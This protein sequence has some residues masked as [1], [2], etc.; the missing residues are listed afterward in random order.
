MAPLPAE[1]GH[2]DLDSFHDRPIQTEL[3]RLLLLPKSDSHFTNCLVIHGMG[4]T[5]KSMAAV[6]VLQEKAI[7]A[8]FSNIYWLVVGADAV[9]LKLQQL[10]S[11]LYKQL[12]GKSVKSDDVLAKGQQ[13]WLD[14]LVEAMTMERS[15]VVLVSALRV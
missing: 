9:D 4:G 6:A 15:L 14:M 11:M 1:V 13:E 8:H 5:G 10:Q 2:Y 7:R 3:V 12:S